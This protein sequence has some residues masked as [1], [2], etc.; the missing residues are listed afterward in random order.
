MKVKSIILTLLVAI[1]TLIWAA[2][3]GSSEKSAVG[4]K[5]YQTVTLVEEYYDG[6][7]MG[8][9]AYWYRFSLSKGTPCSVWIEGGDASEMQL[10]VDLSEDEENAFTTF[11]DDSTEDGSIQFSRLSV[12]DWDE[13]D[14]RTVTFYVCV[15]GDIGASATLYVEKTYKEFVPEGAEEN[16][17]VLTLGTTEKKISGVPFINGEYYISLNLKEGFYYK[18]RTEGGTTNSVLNMAIDSDAED[19]LSPREYLYLPY[20]LETNNA[21]FVVTPLETGKHTLVVSGDEDFTLV[22]QQIPSLT[23]S[24]HKSVKLDEL[25]GFTAE[26]VPGRRVASWDF[27]D[28]IIDEQLFSISLNAGERFAFETSGAVNEIEMVLYDSTGKELAKNKT[29]DGE[30]FDARLAFQVPKKGVYY[31]GVC[32]PLLDPGEDFTGENIT[33]TAVDLSTVKDIDNDE[34]DPVDDDSAG[35]TGLVALP[36]TIQSDVFELGSVHSGHTLSITDWNDTYVVAA[37]KGLSYR[38]GF[39]F[40]DANDES[41]LE[42]YAKV[43]TLSGKTEKEVLSKRLNL[44][45]DAEK[46][47]EFNATAHAAY[48]VRVQVADGQ[49][50][51]Y[52]AYNVHTLAYN[53]DANAPELGIL[54][55][56]TYGAVGAMWSLN[57]ET[58]KYP[59]GASVLVSGEN[60]IKFTAVTGFTSPAAQTV[61]VNAGVEPT[62]VEAYYSDKFDPKD[63]IAK[64][65]TSL[66]LKNTVVEQPRTLWKN[67]PEDNFA[68]AAKDGQ[69]YSIELLNNT[70]DA[71]FS[72]TNAEKGIVVENATSVDKLALAGVKSKYYLTVKHA[73]AENPQNGSYTLSGFLANVGAIKFAKNTMSAKENAAS[74][75][76]TVNRTAK[77]GYVRVKYGTVAGTAVPGV[78]YVAQNGV[79]EWK[80]GDN[81]AKT[82][83]IKLIPDLVANYEGNK[84]FSVQLKPFE[85]DEREESEYPA[86]ITIDSCTVTLTEVSRAGTTVESTYAS[87]AAKLAKV[88]T[89]AVALETGTFYGVLSE[90]GFSLTNGLPAAASVTLTVSTKE[91]AALSAKVILSGKTYNFKGTGWELSDGITRSQTLTL[92]QKVANISYTNTLTVAVNSGATMTEGDWLTGGGTAELVMNVPDKNNKGV[93]EGIRY[94]GNIYRSNEKIQE[95]LN[96]VTNFTG[97]YTVALVPQGVNV[98]DGVPAGNGY[99]TLTV[100]NKGTVKVAGKL[101]DAKNTVSLSAK[102]CGI[103][104]DEGSLIGYSMFVPLYI[105]KANMC[106]GGE[107]RIFVDK[108]SGKAVVDSTRALICNNDDPKFTYENYEGYRMTLEPIGG[109]Y[110]LLVNLQAYYLTMQFMV[111]TPDVY[112][113]PAEAVSTGYQVDDS[114][115]PNGTEVSL[116]GDAFGTAKKALVKDGKLYNLAGSVN[117][118]NVQVKLNRAKGEVSGSFSIWS[119]SDDGTKQKEIT[120]FKHFGVL[121][122][123]RD[124]LASFGPEYASFGY[125]TKSFSVAN[126]NPD[127]GKTVKHTWNFSAPF[128]I[129]GYDQGDIDWWADDWG[130]SPEN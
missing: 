104:A 47:V 56:K 84:E 121:I 63:D 125:C 99:I 10:T 48:Y 50:L 115:Q 72:I 17:R 43:Y 7:P 100:D 20:S 70:G 85:E 110:D 40:A 107:L 31:I 26:F 127:T 108:E 79:L 37:R 15:S 27:A 98:G 16:P 33:I 103:R 129:L 8:G 1:P 54:T 106:F 55:V 23:I 94:S 74:V 78:D 88:K 2:P 80:N 32:N 96:V 60:A 61:T 34:F 126:E 45:A 112:E 24:N 116:T 53:S 44:L 130:V 111:E 52:P 51:D 57:R 119:L 91:P 93:Q 19:A 92:V 21:A 97:Y 101:A 11:T 128:N 42:L 3:K 28:S 35:A 6:E 22:Y 117:P 46:F 58:V 87:K 86:Q 14:P 29:K 5:T 83:E 114:V 102:A 67:D 64:T 90:D 69:Y 124:P 82:I 18:F 89:E 12:E 49:G 65:A 13:E 105:A 122:L 68:F 9:G 109:W 36:G 30:G 41:K 95:Y 75:K 113:I 59:G 62:V 71:V 77:D 76:L 4:L 39:S 73:D 118:C 38:L 25:N 123:A 120:G 66:T 81:K